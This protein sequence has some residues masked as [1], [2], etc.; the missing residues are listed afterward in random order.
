MRKGQPFRIPR[1]SVLQHV[2]F[3]L[4]YS[5]VSRPADGIL[6]AATDGTPGR[7]GV[8]SKKRATCL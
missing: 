7:L 4:N 1:W 2:S 6:V 8:V 5:R 3:L